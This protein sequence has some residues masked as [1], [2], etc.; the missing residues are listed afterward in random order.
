M[1]HGPGASAPGLS[2]AQGVLFAVIADR[3]DDVT[4]QRRTPGWALSVMVHGMAAAVWIMAPPLNADLAGPDSLQVEILFEQPPPPEPEPPQ[5]EPPKPEPPK[6]EPPRPEPPKPAPKPRPAAKPSTPVVSET[7]VSEPAQPVMSE[8]PPPT[9]APTTASA[10]PVA[11][12]TPVARNAGR[13][14]YLRM[15]WSRIMRF[16]P[17][18]V[19]FAG[20]TRLSFILGSDGSLLSVEIAESSGSGLLDSAALEAVRRAAPFPPPPTTF[21]ND[22]AFTI[23]FQF[24]PRR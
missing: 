23:P 19:P 3:P 9:T 7:P 14:D 16:R 5:P 4:I 2:F 12:A 17:D 10:A 13:D 21:G 18:R 11:V 24:R 8:Q 20:T 22:L 6:P 15:V 1:F